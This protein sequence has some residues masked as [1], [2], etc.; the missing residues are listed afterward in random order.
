[1]EEDGGA[2]AVASAEREVRWVV[3]D[4][5]CGAGVKEVPNWSKRDNVTL[6]R[7]ILII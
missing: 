4:G 5:W 7:I 3:N 1:M 2:V 6:F